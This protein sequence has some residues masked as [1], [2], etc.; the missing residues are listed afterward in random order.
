M[1]FLKN[2]QLITSIRGGCYF[3]PEFKR[4]DIAS[5]LLSNQCTESYFDNLKKLNSSQKN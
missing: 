2:Y 3:F 4:F 5:G 1:L